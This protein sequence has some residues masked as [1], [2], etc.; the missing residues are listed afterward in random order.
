MQAW[1]LTDTGNVRRMNQ[2]AWQVLL[3]ETGQLLAVVCD[4]MGGAKSGNIAST[5]TVDVFIRDVK[6]HVKAGMN[7]LELER[8]LTAAADQANREVYDR[9][10]LSEEFEGMGT[11]LVAALVQMPLVCVINVGDSRCYHLHEQ[12]IERVSVDHS[13][14][15]YMLQTGELTEELIFGGKLGDSLD[16][17]G[18]DGLTVGDTALDLKDALGLLGERLEGLSGLHGLGLVEHISVGAGE[19]LV[20]LGLLLV[21]ESDLGKVV[22]VDLHL[23]AALA[24]RVTELLSLHNGQAVVGNDK[25]T[26][27]LLDARLDLGNLVDLVLLWHE[28]HLLVSF[29]GTD[30]PNKT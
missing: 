27:V 22:L 7:R 12:W 5:M 24:K 25:Q 29:P 14:V 28:I 1:G 13:L 17:I 10:R 19:K 21:L 2:D 23:G 26:S 3:L 30:P 15:E 16:L 20:D 9:S 6:K 4:G 8:L 11:T 18:S